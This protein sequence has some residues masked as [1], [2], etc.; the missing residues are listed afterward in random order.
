MNHRAIEDITRFIFLEDT[1]AKC[2]IIFVPGT[3]KSA[4][5]EKAA[6][7][8]RDGIAPLVLPSGKFSSSIGHFAADK[9][10]NLKYYGKYATD[11]AYCEHI[12]M[13]N[14]VPEN[15][16]LREDRATNSM[17]NAM[18]SAEVVRQLGVKVERA[19]ICCQA[20]HARRAYLS[21]ACHFPDAELFVVPTDTQ[22]ISRNDWFKTEKGYRKV[23]G[24]VAKCGA[25]FKDY[26]SV[27]GK[28][29]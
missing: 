10:D 23:M 5:T 28:V 22:G 27:I 16:I 24:E 6:Q 17:E 3:S 14:G 11:F 9:I 29:L 13:E 19:V 1:P 20:F 15:A 25:Y 21:Y 8:Y 26:G 18:Y 12:L 2:D 4:V 7:L